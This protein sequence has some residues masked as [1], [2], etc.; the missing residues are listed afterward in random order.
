MSAKSK[1]NAYPNGGELFR[2]IRH[3]R[4][5]TIK[6]VYGVLHKTAV[7]HFE[8]NGSDIRVTNLM[9]ILKPT[10]TEPQEFFELLDQTNNRLRSLSIQINEAYQNMDVD[11]LE[12]LWLRFANASKEDPPQYLIKLVIENF[13]K[14]IRREKKPFSVEAEDFIQEYLL[15]SGPWFFFEYYVYA[16]LC[17]SLSKKAND[18]LVR[19]ML[20][21]YSH[22]HLES[23]SELFF[24]AFYNLSTMYLQHS[25]YQAALA[26]IH[27]VDVDQL[28]ANV[29]YMRHHII[30]IELATSLLTQQDVPQTQEKLRL[31]LK[32]TKMVDPALYDLNI[33]WLTSLNIDPNTLTVT[34]ES[35]AAQ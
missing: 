35:T 20:K 19:H 31:L 21:E 7:S 12:K 9:T 32:T 30:F 14:D 1:A 26:M 13:L 33:E 34:P 27:L 5:L 23:Y 6:Q 17:Y 25:D 15:A 16:N 3:R 11:Q 4:R 29:L 18:R 10:F 2:A 8:N 24:T 22:F 28:K